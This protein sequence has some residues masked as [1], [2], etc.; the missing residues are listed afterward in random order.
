MQE[1]LPDRVTTVV[2]K[3]HRTRGVGT[4]ADSHVVESDNANIVVLSQVL[5]C[6]TNSDCA[7]PWVL[8]FKQLVSD[9]V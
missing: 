9:D 5:F 1:Q 6:V 3:S 4:G 8:D 7:S 2:N